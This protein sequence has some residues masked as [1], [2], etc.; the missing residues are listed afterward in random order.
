MPL[1]LMMS[2]AIPTMMGTMPSLQAALDKIQ[3]QA[4]G[5][6]QVLPKY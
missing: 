5:D 1:V 3:V 6:L 4:Q 2:A